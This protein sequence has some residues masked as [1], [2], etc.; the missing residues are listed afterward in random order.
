VSLQ[1]CRAQIRNRHWALSARI[2]GNWTPWRWLS[3]F[4]T[5]VTTS[6]GGR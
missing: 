5:R 4:F 2:F 3:I 6:D 1:I